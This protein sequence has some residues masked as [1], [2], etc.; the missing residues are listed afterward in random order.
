MKLLNPIYES[1]TT[2]GSL[3]YNSKSGNCYSGQNN[4]TTACEFTGSGIKND[5]TRGLVSE[6]TYSSWNCSK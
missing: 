1:E 5:K 3:Y 2:G 6:E 4:A